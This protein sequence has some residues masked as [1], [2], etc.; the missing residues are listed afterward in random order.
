MI[1]ISGS[2]EPFLVDAGMLETPADR[3][4]SDH[5]PLFARLRFAALEQR[6]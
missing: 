6:E 4:P 2:L 1:I 3:G 5:V